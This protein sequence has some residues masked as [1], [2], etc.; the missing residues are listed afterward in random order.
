M[1]LQL[2]VDGSTEGLDASHRFCQIHLFSAAH[3]YQGCRASSHRTGA[4]YT[5]ARYGYAKFS[6]SSCLG[7][8]LLMQKVLFNAFHTVSSLAVFMNWAQEMGKK[9][10]FCNNL[11]VKKKKGAFP[12]FFWVLALLPPSSLVPFCHTSYPLSLQPCFCFLC[13]C[14][15]LFFFF[16]FLHFLSFILT[17]FVT[18]VFLFSSFL[19]ASCSTSFVHCIHWTK[20]AHVQKKN[21]ALPL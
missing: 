17:F 19:I 20:G 5:L 16:F 15:F 6:A 7:I 1:S 2:T 13:L 9:M 11:T 3:P 10:C 8:T 14:F 21:S 4:G 12:F 18:M